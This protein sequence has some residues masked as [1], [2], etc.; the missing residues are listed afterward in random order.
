MEVAEGVMRSRHHLR[1]NQTTTSCSIR[2]GGAAILGRNQPHPRHRSPGV[3]IVSLV[4][5][6]IVIMNIML[7]S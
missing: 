1:P 3:V 2:R 6:G 4:I 5:G 7:M